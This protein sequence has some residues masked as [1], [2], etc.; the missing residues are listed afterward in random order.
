MNDCNGF[1]DDRAYS[2]LVTCHYMIRGF[3]DGN[4][5]EEE[6]EEKEICDSIPTDDEIIIHLC[7]TYKFNVVKE[8]EDIYIEVKSLDGEH[9]MTICILLMQKK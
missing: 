8:Y 3:S 2:Y 7:R 5:N 4:Y 9:Q 6:E 1:F